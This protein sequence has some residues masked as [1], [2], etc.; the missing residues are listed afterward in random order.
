MLPLKLTLE[1]PPWTLFFCYLTPERPTWAL[2]HFFTLER[3]P[4]TLGEPLI[5]ERRPLCTYNI[6]SQVD[7]N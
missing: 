1:R 5:P 7:S 6:A 4:W 3:P 2:F